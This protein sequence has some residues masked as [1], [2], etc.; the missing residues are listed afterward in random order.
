MFLIF[1][2]T[3]SKIMHTVFVL[4]VYV[5]DSVCVGGGGGG[6]QVY[7]PYNITYTISGD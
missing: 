5:R 6:A 3:K 7:L 4:C 1:K 2:W